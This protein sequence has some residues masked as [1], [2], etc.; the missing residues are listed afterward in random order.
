MKVLSIIHFIGITIIALLL[1]GC[2]LS[3]P[4][5][6]PQNKTYT[7]NSIQPRWQHF[8][9]KTE[10]TLLVTS[11]IPNPG[12]ASN[13]MIYQDVPYNLRAYANHQW[14]APPSEMLLPLIANAMRNTGY[15]KAVVAVPYVGMTSLRLDT[16]LIALEQDFIHPKSREFLAVQA[17]LTNNVTNKVI[18]AKSFKVSVPAN[19]NTP[20][21]GVLAANRAVSILGNQ[22]ARFVVS[23]ASH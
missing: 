9:K 10:Q 22:L 14:A 21:A 5:K 7:L 17:T 3:T 2:G 11:T 8:S 18:A 23:H 16:R 19:G 6:L 13:K 15:F 12:Y 1:A 4:V 20:Y